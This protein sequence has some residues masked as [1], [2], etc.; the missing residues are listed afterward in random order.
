M[1]QQLTSTQKANLHEVADLLLEIYQTLAS[2]RFLNPA[3][4]IKGPHN[5]DSVLNL[6]EEL[7]LDPSIIYLYSILPYID[8]RLAGQTDFFK[9]GIF[10]DFRQAEDIEQGRDPFYICPGDD[11]YEDEDG[12]YMR[13]WVTPLSLI[14]NHQSVILYD[15]RRHRIWIIDQESWNTSDP[16]LGNMPD[17]VA[18]DEYECGEKSNNDNSFQHVP[19][20]PAGDVLRDMVRWYRSLEI[21]PGGGENTR[22][23]WNYDEL[24]L[25]ELY[26]KH[27]WPDNFNGDAFVADQLRHT[28]LIAD[29]QRQNGEDAT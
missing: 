28:V 20:R 8:C 25:R 3:G 24:P 17:S 26:S 29:A 11:D 18:G 21:M 5:I 14:G 1:D 16:A 13:P 12:P 6:Y 19:S 22:P 15:A 27:G 10:A 2:M 23:E 9:G 4:I 7:G